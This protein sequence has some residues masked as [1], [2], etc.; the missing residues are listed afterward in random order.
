MRDKSTNQELKDMIEQRGK[1]EQ[2]DVLKCVIA[3]SEVCMYQLI[4]RKL[5]IESKMTPNLGIEGI[6]INTCH[7]IRYCIRV[8]RER[9]IKLIMAEQKDKA[10]SRGN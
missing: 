2:F 1:V 5:F 8:S 7:L 9:N 4:I 10:S 3:G 6:E